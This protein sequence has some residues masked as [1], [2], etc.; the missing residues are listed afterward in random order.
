MKKE[1]VRYGKKLVQSGLTYAHFG[2]ISCRQEQMLFISAAGSL[3]DELENSIVRVSLS[4]KDVS[5]SSSSDFALN[6]TELRPS[7]E[8]PIHQAAYQK[9]DA[10]AIVHIH[11]AYAVALS[12]ILGPNQQFFPSEE[13]SRNVLQQIPIVSGKS[14]SSTLATQVSQAFKQ[15]QACIAFKHGIFAK[16]QTVAQA[17]LHASMVEHAAQIRYLTDNWS[18]QIPN[19]GVQ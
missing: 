19:H 14:G 6:K 18:K 11:A 8:L 4:C 2:N 3:L 16:G 15:H 10:M 9:S 17:F 12:I 7:C 5:Q 13:E 1:L